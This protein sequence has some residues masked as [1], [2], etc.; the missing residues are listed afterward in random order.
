MG[1]LQML[2]SARDPVILVIADTLAEYVLPSVAKAHGV[3]MWHTAPMS[4]A[5]KEYSNG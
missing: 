3:P 2:V 4:Y 5:S 1:K